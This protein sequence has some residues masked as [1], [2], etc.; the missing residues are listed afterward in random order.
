MLEEKNHKLIFYKRKNE[1]INSYSLHNKLSLLW[2]T[3]WSHRTFNE[4]SNIIK[5]EKPDICHVHNM[6]PLITPSVYYACN[7]NKVPVVQTI[8]NYRFF[9]TNGFFFRDN[10][11]CEECLNNSAYHALRYGCYRNS[12]IQTYSVARMI[13][14]H[15]K[16]DTWRDKINAF[17]CPSEFVYKKFI[18]GGFPKD[19]L[20][21]KPNFV[22]EDPGLQYKDDD[23]FLFAGRLDYLKGVAT[24]S[25]V[26]KNLNNFKLKFIGEGPEI[27]R[28][29][30][31]A[32]LE[33]L[34]K[35]TNNETLRFIKDSKAV[36]FPSIW[37]ETFG[38]TIIEAFAC[39]KPVIASNLGAMKELIED[40]KTG[41]LF[42]PG[43]PDDL[44]RKIIWA[45]ENKEQLKKMGMEARKV[46]E[47][48]Y[49]AEINYE[50]LMNIYNRVIINK[51]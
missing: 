27:F 37:Y 5:G 40:G 47:E 8:H 13:E 28:L 6:F 46:F 51:K 50:Q 21:I 49:T 20:F 23:Y 29:K 12:R 15:K 41:L 34:G 22:L 39:G 24:L 43:N 16:K 4:I 45:N 25:S 33:I 44:K 7:D 48:K 30:E 32:N 11:I 10:H 42:E 36:V 38:L 17:I 26:A 2:Q 3:S 35:K 1:E 31:N 14:N 9:C 19:K 18:E